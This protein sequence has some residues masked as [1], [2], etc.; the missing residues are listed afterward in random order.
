MPL[1]GLEFS[2]TAKIILQNFYIGRVFLSLKEKR[3]ITE[4]KQ[5]VTKVVSLGS[6]SA[7]YIKS[8]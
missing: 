6:K 5:E 2:G 8:P 1:H 3:L 4:N 7:M